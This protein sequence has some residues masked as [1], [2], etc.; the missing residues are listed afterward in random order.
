MTIVNKAGQLVVL[1]YD[2]YK[3]YVVEIIG[4]KSDGK[5]VTY[6]G[7]IIKVKYL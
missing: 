5:Y 7:E 4:L 6:L 3:M 2:D 1:H